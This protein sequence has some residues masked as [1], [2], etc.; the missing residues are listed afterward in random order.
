M[1]LKNYLKEFWP[2]HVLALLGV[3]ESAVL[4][5]CDESV[6][7]RLLPII[8]IFLTGALEGIIFAE[9]YFDD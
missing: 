2:L 8:I 9:F 5:I 6:A 1:K 3:T 7:V 4:I